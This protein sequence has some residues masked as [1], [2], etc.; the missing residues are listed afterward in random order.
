[1]SLDQMRDPNIRTTP[2]SRRK[3]QFLN[4]R[5][6]SSSVLRGKKRANFKTG[7]FFG[8]NGVVL[9]LSQLQA[10]VISFMKR[11]ISKR[12]KKLFLGECQKSLLPQLESCLCKVGPSAC[13]VRHFLVLHRQHA[14]LKNA[15]RIISE[16]HPKLP[17]SKV[18]FKL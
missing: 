15:R 2:F 10:A 13:S 14:M 6:F 18:I 5:S 3:F 17:D 12:G 16:M 11:V 7:I 1:M 4:C 9:I 8:L